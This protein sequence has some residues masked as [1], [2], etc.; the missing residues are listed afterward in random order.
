MLVNDKK[1][2]VMIISDHFS[3][4]SGV[5]NQTRYMVHAL[6]KSGK[7]SFVYLGGSVKHK[8][9]DPVRYEE[10]GED[11]ILY[12][13]DGYGSSDI[14][15][16]IMQKEK[17]DILWYMSDPRF[18]EWLHL[19]EN[20]V[21]SVIPMAWYCIWDNL[22]YPLYNKKYY[23]CND[24]LVPISK[25][26]EDV[27][28]NV[29]P[30][31]DRIRIPHTVDTNIFKK[32]PD[33]MKQQIYGENARKYVV[34][35]NSRNARRKMTGTLIFWFKEFLDKVGHDKAMLV[36]HTDPKDQNGQDLEQIVKDLNLV[37]GQVVFSTQVLSPENLACMYNAADLTA[38]ISDAE[39]FGISCLESL[40]CET[41]VLVN[42]TGGL[43]EQVTDG[44]KW[45]GKGIKPASQA[46]V[47]SQQVPYIYEDRIRKEDFLR[48]LISLYKK[49]CKNKTAY[50]MMGKNGREHVLK[51][52]GFETFN[53]RWVEVMLKLH[54]EHGSWETRKGYIPWK[55]KEL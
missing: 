24:L 31:V 42:M 32:M 50:N 38:C 21:R 34:F 5:A 47:G 45:F 28:K 54:E 12:P 25:L 37:D 35:Y 14:V 40:S 26:T 43:Q 8:N 17:P 1:I 2:K 29:A 3:A 39:G 27:V 9:Y 22:P 53:R 55:M 15:R 20:E 52:Y 44:K 48:D 13:V 46:I 23:E 30:S 33:Q 16:A 10:F 7:F 11:F 18:Y 6:H 51:N 4:P 19:M 36:L 49:W 41:P